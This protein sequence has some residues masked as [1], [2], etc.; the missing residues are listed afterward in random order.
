[1]ASKIVVLIGVLVTQALMPAMQLI[2]AKVKLV[3]G[4]M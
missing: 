4:K 2:I 1:V 3:A